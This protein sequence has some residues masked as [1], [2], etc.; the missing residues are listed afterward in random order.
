MVG[1]MNRLSSKLI[2][3]LSKN[4][5]LNETDQQ[6]DP[7]RGK[8]IGFIDTNL[9]LDH[10][11]AVS[12]RIKVIYYIASGGAYPYLK[13]ERS[14]DGFP[15]INKVECMVDATSCDYVVF[16]DCYFGRDADELR[17]RGKAVFGASQ[18]WTRIENDR[19]Y[20]WRRLKE[21]G[22][23]VPDGVILNGKKA[24]LD[25]IERNADGK[26]VFYIKT[27]KYRGREKPS[28]VMTRA[29]ADIAID[30][31]EFGPYIDDMEFLI[32]EKCTGKEFGCDLLV[33]GKKLIRPYL[34]TCEEKGSGTVGKWVE[35]SLLDEILIAKIMPSIIETDYRGFIC[36]EFF[37]DEK[38][39]IRVH[40]PCCIYADNEVMTTKGWTKIKNVHAGDFILTHKGRFKKVQNRID[41]FKS[42]QVVIYIQGNSD[43]PL[44]VTPDHRIMTDYGWREAS[45][46]KVDDK[47]LSY[48]EPCEWCGKPI[49]SFKGATNRFCSQSCRTA[50]AD[51]R[52]G[53]IGTQDDFR[54]KISEGK[55]KSWA[56]MSKERRE[57]IAIKV[58][59]GVKE[60]NRKNPGKTKEVSRL[61][62]SKIGAAVKRTYQ[63]DP[64][65]KLRVV[66]GNRRRFESL[67]ES[68]KQRVKSRL[69]ENAKYAYGS[70]RE[71]KKNDSEKYKAYLDKMGEAVSKAKKKQFAENPSIFWPLSQGKRIKRAGTSIELAVR[72]ELTR[73]GIDFVCNKHLILKD[74]YGE[75]VAFKPDILLPDYKIVVECDGDYWHSFE[76]RQ[77]R[78]AYRDMVFE[79]NGYIVL[80]FTETE[81]K[82]N[83]SGCGDQV[84]RMVMNHS[85]R[86]S[87]AMQFVTITR[88]AKRTLKRRPRLVV[89]LTVEEDE[90]F[91]TRGIAVHNCRPGYP[92]SVT[93][94]HLTLNYTEVMTKVAAGEDVRVETNGDP[95][96]VQ[97]GLY[98]DD[99]VTPRTIRFLE[100]FRPYVGFRRA[101]KKSGD[102]WY[103]PGDFLVVTIVTS[104]KEIEKTIDKASEIG[105][106]I[107]VSNSAL[108]GRFKEDV[109]AKIN[110][111]N[112]WNCGIVF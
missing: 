71:M 8:T 44:R 63:A 85:G 37:I 93:Q 1:N 58:S 41:R 14:G 56:D 52:R 20:G 32:Q 39:R 88:I 107:E 24:V 45:T 92:C 55:K 60:W 5:W 61:N 69:S 87:E 19:R 101:V 38:G 67:S 73:K 11:I 40:D 78:D 2:D 30:S 108:P 22:V 109:M 23:G 68:E 80:H 27:S 79:T 50:Y 70:L 31:D 110:A 46:L 16:L 7:L 13:D 104:G 42:E 35:E 106:R 28:G 66:E 51:N 65:Y 89:D 12:D 26:R 96:T 90:S 98:T 111:L 77:T 100:E 102:Y 59:N 57:E 33:N 74:P 91:V 18:E 29:E 97:I 64:T 84:E 15:K 99:K 36:F 49:N 9:G 82:K 81:I 4:A 34:V 48:S 54:K 86:Y 6:D 83:L 25:Y 72:E 112:S 95:Y 10:A 17:K 47:V 3:A 94:T 103:L 76:D 21:M 105:G 62:G 43:K 75:M 53:L